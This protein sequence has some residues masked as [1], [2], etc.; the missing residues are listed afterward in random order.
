MTNVDSRQIGQLRPGRGRRV[1]LWK[2]R[3][4]CGIPV[5]HTAERQSERIRWCAGCRGLARA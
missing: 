1:S 2:A 3:F 4:L 5:G